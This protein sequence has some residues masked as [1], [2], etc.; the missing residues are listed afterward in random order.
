MGVRIF[1]NLLHD[2]T[3]AILSAVGDVPIDNEAHMVTSKDLPA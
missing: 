3:G 2:L 1:L